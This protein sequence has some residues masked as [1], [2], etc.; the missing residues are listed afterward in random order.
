VIKAQQWLDA[1]GGANRQEAVEILARP[2]YV[3]ADAEV[4]GSS[5]TGSFTFEPGDKRAAPDF[6]IFFREY[7]GF[8]FYSDAIWYLTQM[9]RW[10][11][12]KTTNGILILRRLFIA[13]T[14]IGRLQKSWL[15]MV[16]SLVT[17]FLKPMVIRRRKMALSMASFSTAKHQMPILRSSLLD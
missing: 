9:R 14:F 7:A 4:I 1:D 10:G 11:Q 17:L 3:G 16:L 13:Q 6:N 12:I 8:P 15:L 5:M 2:N